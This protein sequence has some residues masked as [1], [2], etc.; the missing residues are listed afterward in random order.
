MGQPLACPCATTAADAA[1]AAEARGHDPAYVALASPCVPAAPAPASIPPMT[2]SVTPRPGT[3][4]GGRRG[5]CD[6]ADAAAVMPGS[7]RVRRRGSS[8]PSHV[9]PARRGSNEMYLRRGSSDACFVVPEQPPQRRGSSEPASHGAPLLPIRR[10]S[11]EPSYAAPT[12]QPRRSSIH[13][14]PPP[15]LLVQWHQG[16]AYASCACG[17]ARRLI[18]DVLRR[19][20]D[21]TWMESKH[22]VVQWLWPK[23]ANGVA[24]AGAPAL[25]DDDARM[26]AA[27]AACERRL[28]EAF[29]MWVEFWGLRRDPGSGLLSRAAGWRERFANIERRGGSHNHLRITRVLLSLRLRGHPELAEPLAEQLFAA[30]ADGSL[31]GA[32]GALLTYWLPALPDGGVKERLQRQA[33]HLWGGAAVSPSPYF[34]DGVRA[35]LV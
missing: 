31:P 27:D 30:V 4:R 33:R 28:L 3:A 14:P 35:A 9:A 23:R 18:A 7:A 11:A 5:S 25:T 17:C 8:E 34:R 19:R 22:H 21:H 15:S 20:G 1:A 16:T 29:D 13:T 26:L 6:P 10:G 2:T 24:G 32:R 12:Q